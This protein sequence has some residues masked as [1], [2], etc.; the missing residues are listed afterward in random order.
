MHE[1]RLLS[2]LQNKSKIKFFKYLWVAG[3]KNLC[4]KMLNV[5]SFY[6]RKFFSDKKPT[7]CCTIYYYLGFHSLVEIIEVNPPKRLTRFF[8]SRMHISLH[9]QDNIRTRYLAF[10][11][12]LK[13]SFGRDISG[14]CDKKLNYLKKLA[15]ITVL[16]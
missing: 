15:L 9:I 11:A 14:Y 5:F 8:N 16:S 1:K 6:G 10:L 12:T 2:C 13:T 4:M 3:R 7:L